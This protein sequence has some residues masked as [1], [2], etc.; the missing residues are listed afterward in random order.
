MENG[1]RECASVELRE[2]EV[3]KGH[4][5][6]R[7]QWVDEVLVGLVEGLAVVGG[8]GGRGGVDRGHCLSG[9]I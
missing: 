7:S 1:N 9:C 2:A 3:R 5:D 8:R 4:G 6:E